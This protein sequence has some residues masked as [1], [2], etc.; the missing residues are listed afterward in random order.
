MTSKHGMAYF[1]VGKLQLEDFFSYFRR[2]F[3]NGEISI[4]RTTMVLL[5]HLL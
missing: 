4:D 2:P 1:V 5:F 3:P